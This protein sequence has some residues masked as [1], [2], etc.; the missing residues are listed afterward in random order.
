L[1]RLDTNHIGLYQKHLFDYESSIEE[2]LNALNDVVRSGEVRYLGASNI[3]TLQLM[4]DE[5]D[6]FSASKGKGDLCLDTE[7][8]AQPRG[9]ARDALFIGG[10]GAILV[11]P[12]SGTA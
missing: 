4:K 8:P 10:R 3:H 9:I 6:W 12:C 1:Q 2:T 11:T 7:L 5:G